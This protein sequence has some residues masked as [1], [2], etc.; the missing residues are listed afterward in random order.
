[1]GV[2]KGRVPVMAA[3][4]F[5]DE[6]VLDLDQMVADTNAMAQV[7]DVVVVLVCQLATQEE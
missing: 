2:N 6:G 3:G 4:T 1:M 5:A 7:A